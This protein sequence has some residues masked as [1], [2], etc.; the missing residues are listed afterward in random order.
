MRGFDTS[1]SIFVDGI[2]DLGSVSRDIFNTQAVEVQQGPA[3]TDN[4]R[5]APTGAINLVSKRAPLES[6]LSGTPPVG[7]AAH[8]RGPA[9][10]N[11]TTSDAGGSGEK[12]YRT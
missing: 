7:V 2:R 4:G 1:N 6:A 12:G 11:Q 10:G 3:G 8:G 9:C 5:T